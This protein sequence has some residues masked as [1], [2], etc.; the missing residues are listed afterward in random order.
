MTEINKLRKQLIHTQSLL[1]KANT[2]CDHYRERLRET[3]VCSTQFQVSFW[4]GYHDIVHIRYHGEASELVTVPR[5]L[6]C[7]LCMQSQRKADKAS[8]QREMAGMQSRLLGAMRRL[9]YV[10]DKVA[11][12]EA[13]VAERDAYVHRLEQQL[14]TKSVPSKRVPCKAHTDAVN[15]GRRRPYRPCKTSSPV[16]RSPSPSP[17]ARTECSQLAAGSSPSNWRTS[18]NVPMVA[19]AGIP[20]QPFLQRNALPKAASYRQKYEAKSKARPAS[21]P[22]SQLNTG[23][24]NG[25]GIG[26]EK[27]HG[28]RLDAHALVA[29]TS[30]GLTVMADDSPRE[31][32]GVHCPVRAASGLSIAF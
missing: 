16:A 9:V 15:T 12:T 21:T 7:M 13:T 8:Y 29:A 28:A 26:T 25:T 11:V 2:Q 14:V 24:P 17:V 19:P 23:C 4:A 30:A 22:E 18:A 31:F 27:A 3:Q 20:C 5:I 32:S 10:A 1:V 6:V